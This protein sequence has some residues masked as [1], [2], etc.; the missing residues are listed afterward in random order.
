MIAFVLS[1]IPFVGALFSLTTFV[2]WLTGWNVE[3]RSEMPAMLVDMFP[4][5]LDRDGAVVSKGADLSAVLLRDFALVALF[6][7]Q[8]SIMA[9][10][11][12]KRWIVRLGFPIYLERSLFVLAS[13][14][15]VYQMPAHAVSFGPQLYSTSGALRNAIQSLRLFGVVFLH[16]ALMS[17]DMLD[18]LGVKQ[19][20]HPEAYKATLNKKP[21]SQ[22]GTQ[23]KAERQRE[24]V[25]SPVCSSLVLCFVS[26]LLLFSSDA[27]YERS[28]GL[29]SSSNHDRIPSDPMERTRHDLGPTLHQLVADRIHPF[30]CVRLRGSGFEMCLCQV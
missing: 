30:G 16:V 4:H 21:V 9:R 17:F 20:W 23:A 3:F 6:G 11:V 28:V 14:I 27:D 24:R 18:L 22:Q 26:A 2:M 5:A 15:A 12:F 1:L 13:N 8:H 29:D 7:L 19:A 25:F 10:P